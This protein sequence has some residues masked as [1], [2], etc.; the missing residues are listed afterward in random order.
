MLLI[1]AVVF[2]GMNLFCPRSQTADLRPDELRG[3]L[4]AS[5]GE[6]VKS[7]RLLSTGL[8]N[9][10]SKLG[11]TGGELF[12][13]E[14]NEVDDQVDKIAALSPDR[15][16]TKVLE[17]SPSPVVDLRT[18]F[19]ENFNQLLN[20]IKEYSSKIIAT[21]EANRKGQLT[22]EQ[23]EMLDAKLHLVSGERHKN[24]DTIAGAHQTLI[25]LNRNHPTTEIGKEA[26][27]LA[28]QAEKTASLYVNDS[29]G[30]QVIDFTVKLTG[31]TPAFSY[32]FAAVI[33]AIIVRILVWP[34]ATKQIMSFKR[35][36]LLQPMMK[37]LKEKYQGQE[38]QVQM[39][40]LYQKY[41]INPLAGCWPLLVQMPFF[42]WI[43]RS[44]NAYRF[45][46]HSGTFLWV[47]PEGHAAAP[48]W[49]GANLGEKDV[50]LI[51]LY[52]IS[53]I[54][55]TLITPTDP[56]QARQAKILGITMAVLFSG[57]MFV[58]PFP[59]A[60]LLY[61]TA[62]NV[63]STA[64]S[65]YLGRVPIPP[66]VEGSGNEKK[67]FFSGLIPKD[68]APGTPATLR[69]NT[70][71]GAPVLHKPKSGKQKKKK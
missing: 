50:P 6:S 21:E 67:G 63:I 61:W 29:I 27:S 48:A 43:F 24:F 68:G 26:A 62:I 16:E 60:F 18:K 30:Y 40:K 47:S 38:L 31:A 19:D 28:V 45:E 64:Q 1:F 44:M 51:L 69:D 49:F 57:I 65:I 32:W 7:G 15:I 23:T 42:I 22:P 11:A 70:K 56:S 52:A 55:T 8:R 20:N 66:L 36:A 3:R 39:G 71:T 4:T 17:P 25:N 35:M 9:E 12:L 37:E 14:A 59:S 2:L 10:A 46:F 33:L 41:N 13:K 53:M 34:L 5:F 54:V 58:S